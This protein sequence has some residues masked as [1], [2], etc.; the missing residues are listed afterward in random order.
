MGGGGGGGIVG[1]ERRVIRRGWV[2]LSQREVAIMLT[3]KRKTRREIEIQ[4][5][6]EFG[7]GR[8]Y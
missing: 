1:G 7:M 5:Q 3:C 2:V 4:Y 6:L 8:L